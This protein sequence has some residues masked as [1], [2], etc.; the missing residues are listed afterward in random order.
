MIEKVLLQLSSLITP[1]KM[2]YGLN[3]GPFFFKS[4]DLGP[5]R[6]SKKCMTRWSVRLAEVNCSGK[7]SVEVGDLN[8]CFTFSVSIFGNILGTVEN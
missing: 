1:D 7:T 5:F 8:K 6:I 2:V 4:L 3:V